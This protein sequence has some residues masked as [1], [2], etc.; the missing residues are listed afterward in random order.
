MSQI[1]RLSNGVTPGVTLVYL[2]GDAGGYVGVDGANN[3]N[4]V[5][6]DGLA[7]LGTPL[8][9]TITF[10][11]SDDMAA[12]EAL[13]GTGIPSR[14]AAN[15]WALNAIT[16]G[17]VLVGAAGNTI[18]NIGPLTTGQFLVGVTGGSPTTVGPLT[19][20]QLLIG[21]TGAS[22]VA[23]SL[24]STGGSVT[25][26]GGAGSI[27]LEAG[28]C[29][30]TTFTAEDASTATPAANILKIVG[31]STNGIDTTAAGNTVTI[32]MGTSLYSDFS[33]INLAPATSRT[34]AITNTDAAAA[35]TSELR[36]SVPTGGS[37]AMVVWEVQGTRFYSLGVDNSAGDAWKLTNS[38][39]TSAGDALISITPTG[40]VTLFNDLDVTEGGTGVSTLTSHGILLGNGTGDI[41]ATAEPSD[42]QILIGD[43]SGFPILSTLTAGSGIGIANAAGS[44]TISV[45]ATVPTTFTAE[46]AS[47][48]S[49]AA[50]N[51]NI[52]GTATNGIDTTAAGSTVTI[53]MGT[54]YSDGNFS[55]TTS[56]AGTDRSLTVSNSDN[57]A[58]A[59]A[60]HMQISVGGSTSTG[61]PYTNYLV[62]GAGTFSVG[63]DN[64][65]SDNFKITSGATPSAGTDLFKMTSAGVI[66][67]ANDLDVSEGGTGVSTLTSHGI[68]L[69]NGAGDIQATAE[70]S[71]GQLIIG[72]TGN[73]PSAATLT[74]GSGIS[75]TNAAGSV[76]I[77]STG[78]G[79][80]WSVVAVDTTFVVN[81]GYGSNAA[82]A[83]AF[84]LPAASAVGDTV[85]IQGMQGSWNVVQRANQQ[86]HIGSGASTLGAGGSISST[87]AFDAIEL[88]CLVANSI[89]YARSVVGNITIV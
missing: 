42:G 12:I 65:D 22:P 52:V 25:I 69:G 34:L 56:S 82:G 53:G 77:A 18:T 3:I 38:S 89:W 81:N 86:I 2:S 26:T 30:P 37:D 11:L 7:T 14:T 35:S 84:T 62:S 15:T 61:D 80:A 39:S 24:T 43:T 45:G 29:V 9:N 88:V 44:I 31:T 27:N 41:Q 68:L 79:L 49:P 59:S 47:T 32:G 36:L 54:S 57:S 33:F 28:T 72:S 19:S 48:C 5:T 76:T 8:A 13:A 60:A 58:A 70:L 16:S 74:A 51:I 50:N 1:A 4:L 71:N 23:S 64:S 63:I 6:G 46:N 40:V 87:N 73:A 85:A 10:S 20:G 17:A 21:S 83:V 66:T 75:I 78:G 55:F 67:L